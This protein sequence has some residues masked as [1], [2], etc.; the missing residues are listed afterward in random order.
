MH[1]KVFSI[2]YFRQIPQRVCTLALFIVEAVIIN[3]PGDVNSN[4]ADAGYKKPYS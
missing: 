1:A 3:R 4:S 2:Q